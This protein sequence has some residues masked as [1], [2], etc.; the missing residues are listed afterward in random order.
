MFI[1]RLLWHFDFFF[2]LIKVQGKPG[3]GVGSSFEA[4]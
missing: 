2:T 1:Q 3:S 4:F